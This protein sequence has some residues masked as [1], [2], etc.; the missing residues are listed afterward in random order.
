[1]DGIGGATYCGGFVVKVDEPNTA[2]ILTE[3]ELN[4]ALENWLSGQQLANA[5]SILKE[6]KVGET[7]WKVNS[8]FTYAMAM[9]EQGM[10]TAST[11]WTAVNNW[12]S[13]GYPTPI[14]FTSPGAGAEH[15]TRK[16]ATG[17]NYF[18]QGKYTVYEIGATFCTD[19]PPPAWA[20]SVTQIMLQIYEAAGKN[21]VIPSTSVGGKEELV[22]FALAQQ[23]KPY[24]SDQRKRT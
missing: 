11:S 21:V 22:E 9:Q 10:G 20:E 13:W 16:I 23:G 15:V 19:P 4:T 18:S 6:V 3:S 7:T 2:P 1:M 24:S 12:F 14:P 8:V 5:K 17:N